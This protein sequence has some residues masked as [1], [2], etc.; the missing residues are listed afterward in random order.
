MHSLQYYIACLT[1]LLRKNWKNSPFEMRK[2]RF[3]TIVLKKYAVDK[4][5]KHDYFPVANYE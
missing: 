1:V 4:N 2:C 3:C 5:K